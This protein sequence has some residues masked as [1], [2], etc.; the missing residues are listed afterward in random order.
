MVR[1]VELE[2]A[3]D[4]LVFQHLCADVEV[5]LLSNPMCASLSLSVIELSP[6]RGSKSAKF[7]REEMP[8]W[9]RGARA[10]ASVLRL[11]QDFAEILW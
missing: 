2:R 9:D 10:L 1:N 3:I 6:A 5:T 7:S 11:C 4:A 8:L